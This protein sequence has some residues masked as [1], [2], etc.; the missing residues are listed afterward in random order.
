M[1]YIQHNIPNTGINDSFLRKDT[2]VIAE[3]N[4]IKI[5]KIK[6]QRV[7][8]EANDLN[9]LP[10]PTNRSSRKLNDVLATIAAHLR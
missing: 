5:K 10:K 4:S 3:V 7:R 9:H 6:N 8:I 1:R 2:T